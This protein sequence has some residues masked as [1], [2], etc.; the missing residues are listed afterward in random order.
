MIAGIPIYALCPPLPQGRAGSADFVKEMLAGSLRR[1]TPGLVIAPAGTVQVEDEDSALEAAEELRGAARAAGAA[2]V[3][4]IDVGPPRPGSVR[5]FA[6]LGGAPAIWGAATGRGCP[7]DLSTRTLR[8][9]GARLLLLAAPEALDLLAPRRVLAAG[10]V[11]A[12]IIL[13]HGGAT[14]RWAPALARLER[15][16]PILVAAHAGGAG[17]AYATAKLATR[18][19]AAPSVPVAAAPELVRAAS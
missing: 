9:G 17:R 16:A 14:M 4:A 1:E 3:F 13:S 11:D 7:A 2:L 18:W 19:V 8:I 5:L 15:S 10:G 6:C 12:I